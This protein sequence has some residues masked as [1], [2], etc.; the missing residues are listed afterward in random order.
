MS[1][2]DLNS[3]KSFATNHA[4]NF[5]LLADTEHRLASDLGS[6]QNG[7]VSRDTFLI[8]PDGTVAQVW[9]AVDPAAT[10]DQVY[11]SLKARIETQ[12]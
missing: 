3:H 9:R 5:P 6:Y 10:S 12:P 11:A 7:M 1:A 8:A 2:D 4:L